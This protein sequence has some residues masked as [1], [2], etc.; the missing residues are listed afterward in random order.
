MAGIFFAIFLT[1]FLGVSVCERC[2]PDGSDS[3]YTE[4]LDLA[5]RKRVITTNSCPDHFSE[6]QLSE[7]AGSATYASSFNVSIEIPLYPRFAS[8]GHIRSLKCSAESVA[9]ALNGVEIKSMN[10]GIRDCGSPLDFGSQTGTGSE[11]DFYGISDGTLFCGD[12][13]FNKASTFDKCGGH[14]D[15]VSG[16]YH[17][18]FP[19]VCLLNS[20]NEK[21]GPDRH[22]V[23]LG[24]AF[25][26]FPVY[27]PHGPDGVIMMKCG[28]EGSHSFFC[29]D[30][31]NGFFGKLP[32]IDEFVYRYYLTG[33]LGNG[34]CNSAVLANQDVS[35]CARQDGS[36]CIDKVPSRHFAPYTLGCFR[37]CAFNDNSCVLSDVPGV[38]DGYVPSVAKLYRHI[39]KTNI[40]GRDESIRVHPDQ[41]VHLDNEKVHFQP[42]FTEFASRVSAPYRGIRVNNDGGSDALL[43]NDGSESFV[44]GL[45]LRSQSN[46]YVKY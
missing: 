41:N 27:G 11:C 16:L 44:T 22:D 15:I 28:L 36:C 26:G 40:E 38:T 13:V 46:K 5:N 9:V 35:L 19:P 18:H 14:T 31:C 23:Q 4:T 17:Y 24:W 1:M 42:S 37:G 30:D 39:D 20:L 34:E 21:V 33:E 2:N 25:D 43:S 3:F 8:M 6:C 29:L 32:G 12:H 7:C 45:A 10:D